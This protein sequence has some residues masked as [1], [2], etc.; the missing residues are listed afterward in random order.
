MTTTS[1][2]E[3][4]KTHTD[5]YL[6]KD[7]IGSVK[8]DLWS[9]KWK[10]HP[11]FWHKDQAPLYENY[12]SFYEAGKAMVKLYQETRKFLNKPKAPKINLDKD[13]DP[14]GDTDEIDM[15]DVFNSWG[16]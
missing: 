9:Q 3:V 1:F 2:K 15:R 11:K 12:L 5:I 16:P 7:F 8:M 4:D 14:L 6:N 13:R 10:I